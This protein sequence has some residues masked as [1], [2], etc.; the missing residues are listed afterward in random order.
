MGVIGAT[1][2]PQPPIIGHAP[3]LDAAAALE[4]ARQNYLEAMIAL[5]CLIEATHNAPQNVAGIAARV[6]MSVTCGGEALQQAEAINLE[7]AG[8]A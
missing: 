8:S 2:E 5:A 3:A 6:L 4:L 7:C 1:H